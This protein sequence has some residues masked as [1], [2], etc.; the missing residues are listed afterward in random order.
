M[1]KEAVFFAGKNKLPATVV[2]YLQGFLND[3]DKCK[4]MSL[5]REN[6]QSKE[7]YD[8]LTVPAFLRLKSPIS[9]LN[10]ISSSIIRHAQTEMKLANTS[11]EHYIACRAVVAKAQSEPF[12]MEISEKDLTWLAS[13]VWEY[14]TL[15]RVLLDTQDDFRARLNTQPYRDMLFTS[16]IGS[17]PLNYHV[18]DIHLDI[19]RISRW[20]LLDSNIAEKD[21]RRYVQR[22]MSYYDDKL[23]KNYVHG[24]II[25]LLERYPG[26]LKD[27][28]QE[29]LTQPHA[30]SSP[31]LCSIIANGN[32]TT[33]DAMLAQLAEPADVHKVP[34]YTFVVDTDETH[35]FT[36][37]FPFAEHAKVYVVKFALL[38][39]ELAIHTDRK[40]VCTQIIRDLEALNKTFGYIKM[41]QDY[42]MDALDK[43][44]TKRPEAFESQAHIPFKY[45][46]NPTPE[47]LDTFNSLHVREVRE[48]AASYPQRFQEWVTLASASQEQFLAICAQF[49]PQGTTLTFL[50]ALA[51]AH[52]SAA[53]PLKIFTLQNEGYYEEI[54]NQLLS[55]HHFLSK[56]AYEAM[57]EVK[58]VWLARLLARILTALDA[59]KRIQH[60]DSSQC[61]PKQGLLRIMQPL[62]NHAKTMKLMISGTRCGQIRHAILD[63]AM[64]RF[65][66]DTSI[67]N[68][69][70]EAS[71]LPACPSYP[72]A[73]AVLERMQ[74]VITMNIKKGQLVD[75]LPSLHCLIPRMSEH[76]LWTI[77][78]DHLLTINLAVCD[79]TE[80]YSVLKLIAERLPDSR[81]RMIDFILDMLA[82]N[83]TPISESL[84]IFSVMVLNDVMPVQTHSS[85]LLCRIER[86]IFSKKNLGGTVRYSSKKIVDALI[87]MILRNPAV[88]S[89]SVA[90]LGFDDLPLRLALSASG[91]NRVAV[92]TEDNAIGLPERGPDVTRM[93]QP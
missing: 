20:Y 43:I 18:Q 35:G 67:I 65:M 92:L 38:L 54:V 16:I 53:V 57:D 90:N 79:L 69:S 86:A 51:I 3:G 75:G 8:C 85:D 71:M 6:A 63:I 41:A 88:T 21:L 61:I 52:I 5:D 14:T 80:L 49:W 37:I 78:I 36:P 72:L 50:G 84:F 4:L 70:H 13:H 12:Q 45:P 2:R 25:P 19:N 1:A 83:K 73:P 42:I 29:Y 33:H 60:N 91:K 68:C 31:L 9:E 48:Y 28:I 32:R 59:K 77:F 22:A 55:A 10:E 44:R 39:P 47:M 76:D 46:V 11:L 40:E 58:S 27:F 15:F 66:R 82:N 24:V 89:Q 34:T 17:R 74:A 23:Q 30:C 93:L 62:G 56:E 26:L 64:Q 7:K 87:P 81:P